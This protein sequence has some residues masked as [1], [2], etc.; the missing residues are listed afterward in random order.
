VARRTSRPY[1]D[2]TLEKIRAKQPRFFAAVVED[3]RFAAHARGERDEFHGRLDAA[4]QAVRLMC[5]TDAFFAQA[6]Y[7]AQ[8]RLD[9]LRVPVLPY[10]AKRL[11][12]MSA[13]V[14]VGR[15][16]VIHPGILIGHGQ[17]VIDGFAEIHSGVSIFPW[18]TIGLRGN[19]FRG[20]VIGEMVRIG[21]GAKVLGAVTVHR[22]AKIGANAVVITD[23]PAGVTMVGA[24]A[25]P[26]RA[27]D[28]V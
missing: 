6:C 3:A 2:R 16:V 13:Q 17:V 4:L 24:P 26:V 9:A 15:T 22:G 18:V 8:A 7:R 14:C 10:V 28:A 11:A 27:A 12:M 25:R 20:P 19:Q 1:F 5:V 21:T 23:V